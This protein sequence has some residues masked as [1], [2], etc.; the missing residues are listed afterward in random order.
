MGAMGRDFLLVAAL[1]DDMLYSKSSALAPLLD[2]VLRAVQMPCIYPI[3][4]LRFGE[5]QRLA[6][7][8][9]K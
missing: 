1:D 4:V 5:S 9:V 3:C 8:P 2:Q 6:G 7:L